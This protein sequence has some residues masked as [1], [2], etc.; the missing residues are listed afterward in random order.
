MIRIWGWFSVVLTEG[1][2]YSIP[3]H[4]YRSYQSSCLQ[5]DY[6]KV[7]FCRKQDYKL[8]WF[9]FLSIS[10]AITSPLSFRFQID[11]RECECKT[12]PTRVNKLQVIC[13]KIFIVLVV[14]HCY[15]LST[16]E[17]KLF[18]NAPFSIKNTQVFSRVD[19]NLIVIWDFFHLDEFLFSNMVWFLGQSSIFVKMFFKILQHV[20]GAWCF[21]LWC[22]AIRH[23]RDC[24]TV[25]W[26]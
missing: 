15:V 9:P 3:F 12:E 11:I 23:S 19:G 18:K 8:I 6:K 7:A 5:F 24:G 2:K 4:S 1:E 14:K 25:W 16:S 26:I 10:F 17:M 21:N 22:S 13:F 20:R